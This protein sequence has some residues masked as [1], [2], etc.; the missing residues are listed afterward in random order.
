MTKAKLAPEYKEALA[1]LSSRPEFPLFL[2]FLKVQLNNI[3]V[4][5]W[6]N[7]H[8]SDPNLHVRK[9]NFEGQYEFVKNLI[10]IFESLS[11]QEE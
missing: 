1:T 8:A 11:K 6:L 9:A 7:T 5:E 4:V 3:A 2:K 10:S